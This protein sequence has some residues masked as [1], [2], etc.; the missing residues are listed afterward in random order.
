MY[1]KFFLLLWLLFL[2]GCSDSEQPA[3]I[4]PPKNQVFTAKDLQIIHQKELQQIAK[5]EKLSEYKDSELYKEFANSST[6]VLLQ[7]STAN[8]T[9][10]TKQTK[11]VSVVVATPTAVDVAAAVAVSTKSIKKK[12][13]KTVEKAKVAANNAGLK[14][15]DSSSKVVKK[16][17]KPKYRPILVTASQEKSSF[18]RAKKKGDEK[19]KPKHIRAGTEIKAKLSDS[20]SSNEQTPI[21]ISVPTLA[22]L[23]GSIKDASIACSYGLDR[24]TKRMIFRCT[25]LEA[26]AFTSA[27]YAEV[28]DSHRKKGLSGRL[29]KTEES[30]IAKAVDSGANNAINNLL[31][32]NPVQ[33]AL[34]TGAKETVNNKQNKVITR[35]I[36]H[37]DEQDIIIRFL[38]SF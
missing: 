23:E 9:V 31:S 21:F 22:T 27:I 32:Q 29:E 7:V 34:K 38:R 24:V 18:S 19:E 3:D 13:K 36:L 28:L 5:G 35:E 12:S 14:Q 26:D 17:K 4:E 10:V 37:V 20:I 25:K 16:P 8:A 15:P 33:A 11:S 1:R 2:L 6:D 30:I